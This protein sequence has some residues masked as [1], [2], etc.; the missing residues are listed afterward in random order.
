MSSRSQT[1]PGSAS[2]SRNP[3]ISNQTV[4]PHAPITP[5]GLRESQTA[6]S[7]L[8]DIKSTALEDGEATRIGSVEDKD[9]APSS[10]EASPNTYP[11]HISTDPAAEDD[12]LD[13]RINRAGDLSE[14]ASEFTPLLQKPFEFL[15]STS[16]HEG[17]CGHGTFSPRADSIRSGGSDYGF[18]G[19]PQVRGRP[20]SGEGR[21][22]FSSLLDTV[23]MKN[24][25]GGKK[26][27]STTSYLAEQHGIDTRTMYG[28][29]KQYVH[30]CYTDAL[31]LRYFPYYIPALAWI[32]Q[33]RCEVNLLSMLP[34]SV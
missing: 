5:S 7:S 8:E 18:G 4:N 27:M 6:H 25:S 24:G 23:G 15:L 31:C 21:S 34:F 30:C 2:S 32:P 10:S 19:A 20:D 3:L 16:P 33:Y 29:R 12:A 14:R 26:K 28:T 11:T 9:K 1:S 13:G 22:M 17:P